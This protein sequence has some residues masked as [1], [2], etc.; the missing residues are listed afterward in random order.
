MNEE[1]RVFHL[2]RV[3][4][5]AAGTDAP[6]RWGEFVMWHPRFPALVA[7]ETFAKAFNQAVPSSYHIE[8]R[9]G[10]VL[11][12]LPEGRTFESPDK[13]MRDLKFWITR[14]VSDK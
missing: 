10:G 8:F 13:T 14:T 2:F 11:G 5:K 9:Y 6:K 7:G 3:I 12:S 1:R 4:P